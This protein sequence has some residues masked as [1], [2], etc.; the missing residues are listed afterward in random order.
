MNIEQLLIATLTSGTM[1]A[2]IAL[3][4]N[5]VYGT[6]RL[7]NIAHGELV[8]LGGYV[9]YFGFVLLGINPLVSVVIAA[10]LGALAGWLLYTGLLRNLIE[11]YPTVEQLEANQTGTINLMNDGRADFIPE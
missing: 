6:T 5:L 2:L 3:G 7:L 4:L 11:K 10:A 1:Y 8:M 9:A